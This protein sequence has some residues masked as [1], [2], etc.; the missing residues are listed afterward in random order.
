MEKKGFTSF[1]SE[2]KCWKIYD[3]PDSKFEIHPCKDE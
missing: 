2:V 3:H 1:N